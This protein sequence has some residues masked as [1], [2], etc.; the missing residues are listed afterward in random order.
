MRGG[1]GLTDAML[2]L[3]PDA[4]VRHL[5][6]FKE[7]ASN[8]PIEYYNKLPS[9]NEYDICYI[10]DPVIATGGTILAAIDMIKELGVKEIGVVSI[11]CSE[12]GLGLIAERHPDVHVY[13]AAIDPV[14]D[15][16]GVIIPGIGDAGDRIFSN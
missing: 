8:Q 5:G 4:P 10:L 15:P 13:C 9:Q 7:K 12:E 16:S 14:L 1:I 2:T 11:C 6:I 3:I